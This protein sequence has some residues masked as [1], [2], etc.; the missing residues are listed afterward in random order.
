MTP[1]DVSFAD[2]AIMLLTTF[3]LVIQLMM[4]TQ[5][6]L[7]ANINLFAI[8]SL[9]LCGVAATVALQHGATHLYFIIAIM[10]GGKVL[11]LPIFLRRMVRKIGILEELKPMLNSPAAMLLC[12][13]LALLG[14]LVARPFAAREPLVNSS[15]GI[16]ISVVLMGFFLMINRR[17]A[18][19]QVLALMCAENGLYL[20]AISLTTFGMPL[21]VELGIFFDLF[22]AVMV[23]GILVFRIRETFSTIDVERLNQ[24]KG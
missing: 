2:Q 18:I 22:V 1:P 8:Q 24:L 15:F 23:L 10:F 19:N 21:V 7:S 12:G 11:A 9:L 6:S 4:V 17:T 3:I 13:G 14:H 20:A 5:R 16:A